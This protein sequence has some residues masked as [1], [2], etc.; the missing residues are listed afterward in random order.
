MPS[1]QPSLIEPTT[2]SFRL[3]EEPVSECRVV[4]EQET[5]G[6]PITDNSLSGFNPPPQILRRRLEL[7]HHLSGR[8]KKEIPSA[9][10]DLELFVLGDLHILVSHPF[11]HPSGAPSGPPSSGVDRGKAKRIPRREAERQRSL[12]R[13]VGRK[14]CF[15]FVS[16]EPFSETSG[17]RL[18]HRKRPLTRS[19]PSWA[20]LDSNQ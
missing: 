14:S 2:Q 4:T 10:S 19:F 8:V 16:S 18:A 13:A 11:M 20:L 1:P 17:R 15:L 7:F 12:S 3:S 5:P 6:H 9:R